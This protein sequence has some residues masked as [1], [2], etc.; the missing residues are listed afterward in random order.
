M[1]P[2]NQ[3]LRGRCYQ[4]QANEFSPQAFRE[5][6][7]CEAESTLCTWRQ[8]ADSIC[9]QD[10]RVRHHRSAFLR[11]LLR[12]PGINHV[13]TTSAHVPSTRNSSI[14]VLSCSGGNGDMLVFAYRN[15]VVRRHKQLL[16][17]C[18]EGIKLAFVH[19]TCH[20]RMKKAGGLFPSISR[21]PNT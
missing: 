21:Q 3:T 15:P 5:Y 18:Y 10:Q 20:D 13:T 11:K 19:F 2:E 17:S 12:I 7:C 14:F 6:T 8:A 1:S 4:T 16:D 9:K